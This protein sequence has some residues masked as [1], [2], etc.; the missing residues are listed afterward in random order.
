MFFSDSLMLFE[1]FEFNKDVP[2]TVLFF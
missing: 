1:C 2:I